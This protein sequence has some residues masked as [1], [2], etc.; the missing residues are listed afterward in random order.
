MLNSSSETHSQSELSQ[1][2]QQIST[3]QQL[4]QQHV[5]LVSS[6][7]STSASSSSKSTSAETGENDE[8]VDLGHH[9]SQFY[10]H[11]GGQ[12]HIFEIFDAQDISLWA[13]PVSHLVLVHFLHSLFC[14]NPFSHWC[15]ADL[16]FGP[17]IAAAI[18]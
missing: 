3:P 5:T 8:L 13:E 11:F 9:F 18:Q 17:K 7:T 10:N 15:W 16:C 4:Q 1:Q 12:A 6:L 2:Q 14:V